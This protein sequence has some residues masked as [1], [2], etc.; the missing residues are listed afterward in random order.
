MWN[1]DVWSKNW[2]PVPEFEPRIPSFMRQ[3]SNQ[4]CY[5]GW[6]SSDRTGVGTSSCEKIEVRD[7]IALNPASEPY[8]TISYN[9]SV[10]LSRNCLVRVKM[11]YGIF[12]SP[13]T[14]LPPYQWLNRV[15]FL[16]KHTVLTRI[17]GMGIS[18]NINPQ[19][20]GAPILG[21]RK[22]LNDRIDRKSVV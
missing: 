19:N 20:V 15:L 18:Q 1:M 9:N 8:V 17:L 6:H 5:A 11:V 7:Q 4:L 21:N 22:C 10:S 14:G 13:A 12:Q 3:F 16:L 2:L